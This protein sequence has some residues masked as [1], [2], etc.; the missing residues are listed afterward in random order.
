VFNKTTTAGRAYSRSGRIAIPPALVLLVA[1]GLATA[2]GSTTTA[3]TQ[4]PTPTAAPTPTP[5][6]SVSGGGGSGSFCSQANTVLSQIAQVLAAV[7]QPGANSLAGFKA[8]I[9]ALAQG[10]DNGDGTA[11]SAIAGAIHTMRVAYDQVN[12]G[13]QSATSLSQVEAAFQ[14]AANTAV[15]AAGDQVTAYYTANCSGG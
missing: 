5:T 11:P 7:R 13:L 8:E 14:P 1:G 4:T 10:L 9:G 12:T 2:C 15:T 3:T 6:A